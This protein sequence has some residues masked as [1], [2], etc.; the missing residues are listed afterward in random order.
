MTI[1]ISVH[2]KRLDCKPK[3]IILE[4]TLV[5]TIFSFHLLVLVSL[6]DEPLDLALHC[7]LP[8][9]EILHW[10]VSIFIRL[11][12]MQGLLCLNCERRLQSLGVDLRQLDPTSTQASKYAIA[13]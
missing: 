2:C 8:A 4:S 1:I 6:V 5:K 3:I 9:G 13:I 12:P 11:P 10:L 7:R